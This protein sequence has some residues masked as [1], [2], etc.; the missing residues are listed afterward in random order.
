M[1]GH[2][3][4]PVTMDEIMHTTNP[5]EPKTMDEIMARVWPELGLPT[6][7]LLVCH[8]TATEIETTQDYAQYLNRF[9]GGRM[10]FFEDNVETRADFEALAAEAG[11]GYDLVVY[12]EPIQPHRHLFVPSISRLAAKEL[13]TSVLVARPPHRQIAKI[14]MLARGQEFDRL[15]A[16]WLMR[17]A[18]LERIEVTVL[19]LLP[20][21]PAIYSHLL[22][23]IGVSQWLVSDTPWSELLRRINRDLPR[24]QV[25]DHLKFRSG[26]PD[27]QVRTEIEESDPDLI[28][29]GADPV[30]WWQR[31]IVGAL[32][33][34]LLEGIDRPIL[35]AKPA[36]RAAYQATE[37]ASRK[38]PWTLSETETGVP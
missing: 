8:Q 13:P 27:D 14:L 30:S 5:G 21:A 17:F 31:R 35:V 6:L 24:W 10:R 19:V 11:Q 25:D 26:S 36:L 23:K 29:V 20:H 2:Q 34:Q 3:R 4:H 22:H 37:S 33:D 32:V 38:L 28:I 12:G 9:L 1:P 7:R 16:D 18:K 15:A